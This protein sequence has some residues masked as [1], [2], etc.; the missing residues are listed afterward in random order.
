M[1]L[2]DRDWA[3]EIDDLTTKLVTDVAIET[4]PKKRKANAPKK[5]SEK[6]K[7]ISKKQSNVARSKDTK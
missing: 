7:K 2:N 1:A 3:L 4:T 5:L 6:P